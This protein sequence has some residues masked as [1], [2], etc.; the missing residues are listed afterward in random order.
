MTPAR[1]A[2]LATALCAL[3]LG[4]C[5]S[6]SYVGAGIGANPLPHYAANA[7]GG[8]VAAHAPQMSRA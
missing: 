8:G 1:L 3:A 2:I 5:A 6:G 4:G 7:H